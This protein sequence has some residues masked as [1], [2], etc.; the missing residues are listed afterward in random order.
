MAHGVVR[1]LSLVF[2]G[3]FAG[4]LVCVAVLENSL[5]GFGASIY[6]QVR[7]VELDSLDRLASVTLIP[8]IVTTVVLAIWARG[9]GRRLVL[10]ALVLLVVVFATTLAINLPI[11]SD[12][13][14]WSVQNPP[15]DWAAVRDRWQLAH[16]IR[17]AAALLAFGALIGSTLSTRQPFRDPEN[18]RRVL[19]EASGR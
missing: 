14:S 18:G 9:N 16:L 12:Q 8:A 13:S 11:N 1:G 19:K 17:T 7:L 15:A 10:V 3:V 5:R 2:S 6:T 4:F